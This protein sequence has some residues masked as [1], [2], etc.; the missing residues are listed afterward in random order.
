MISLCLVV[1]KEKG[2]EVR[3]TLLEMDL[4]N[5]ELVIQQ[6]GDRL[7]IPITSEVDLGYEI[8]E[9][10]FSE[11]RKGVETYKNLIDLPEDLRQYLPTSYDVIGHVAI[12]KIPEELK[13]YR[14]SIAKALLD[15][16]KTI[17]SVVEDRGVVGEFRIRDLVHLAGLKSLETRHREYGLEFVIDPSKVY[18][19][20]RL[21][22]ER[23]RVTQLVKEG[24]V[25]IDMFAGAGPLAIMVAKHARPDLVYAIDANPDAIAYLERNVNLNRV[26][27]VTPLFG[28]AR[29][30]V[31]RCMTANRI[32]MDLPHSAYEFID[33]ALSVSRA[34]T[35]IHYHEILDKRR[36]EERSKELEE[37]K[38]GKLS[39]SVQQVREVRTY[40]PILRHYVF[41]L[42]VGRG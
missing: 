40:S 7:F 5:K 11:V 24:E 28:D 26:E 19:S 8:T 16:S 14:R 23:W 37:T 20:P 30:M 32:V 38:A 13:S 22:T 21:A 10:E 31:N 2:E 27:N 25:V 4:L 33:S 15:S 41:D 35:V 9:G 3:R 36:V 18:F 29:E 34:G 39:L 17:K 1:P 6:A 12:L 42:R